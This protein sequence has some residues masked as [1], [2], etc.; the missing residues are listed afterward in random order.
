MLLDLKEIAISPDKNL[1]C[2]CKTAAA[3]EKCIDID[4]LFAHYCY[5]KL[6]KDTRNSFCYNV[7]IWLYY[8]EYWRIRQVVKSRCLNSIPVRVTIY[9]SRKW[10]WKAICGALFLA[11]F[12]FVRYLS[13]NTML[14]Q[15]P[16]KRGTDAAQQRATGAIDEIS[17]DRHFYVLF[18]SFCKKPNALSIASATRACAVWNI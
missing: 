18:S 10:L 1:N 13:A 16:Q 15:L 7:Q 2:C 17:A 9:Q 5:K 11:K 3:M 8:A 4:P 14:V 6:S 12:R